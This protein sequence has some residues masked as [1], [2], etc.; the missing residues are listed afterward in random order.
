MFVLKLSS[1]QITFVFQKALIQTF[2]T[3]FLLQNILGEFDHKTRTLIEKGI[4]YSKPVLNDRT[5]DSWYTPN[6]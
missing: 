4:L 1:V 2:Y 5:K 3:S 6:T